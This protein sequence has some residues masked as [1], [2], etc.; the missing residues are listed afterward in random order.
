[1]VINKCTKYIIFWVIISVTL[2]TLF[3]NFSHYSLVNTQQSCVLSQRP[4]KYILIWTSNAT[5]PMKHL[6]VEKRTFLN[7]A[8]PVT[9]CFVS[10]DRQLLKG[11]QNYDVVVFH[12]PELITRRNLLLPTS[13]LPHQKY[14]FMSMESSDY[15]PIC[16]PKYNNYFNWTWTYKIN[17]DSYFGYI[18]IKDK[19]GKAIGPKEE[20]QWEKV[21]N[22]KPINDTIK[23]KISKKKYAAA[24]FVSNCNA[25]SGRYGVARQ[26]EAEL[27]KYNMTV[28]I[29]GFCGK[30]KCPKDNVEKCMRMIE[31]D[32]Y[33]YLSFENSM[34]A[35]YVTEKLL[36]ALNHYAVP[37][38]FGDANY[39]RYMPDGIYL[40]ITK[41]TVREV[42]QNMVNII[43]DKEQYYEYF[44]WHNHYTYSDGQDS[45]ETDPYC[46]LC[47]LINDDDKFLRTSV[48]NNFGEWWNP[49]R[50]CPH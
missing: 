30:K 4:L 22:M 39:T 3:Y 48:Y 19:E 16:E 43:N 38:V 42:A 24:W 36:T 1:M 34:S 40:T 41:D 17:S 49:P 26:L 25:R 23:T 18:V 5:D 11:V 15:Y 27:A 20:M 45:P 33:F 46:N 6:L 50:R 28:D 13:R 14:I 7:R 35:D 44:K 31:T 8:C 37:V 2:C 32:Y 29:F 10:S 47:L 21:E 9:N 12:G